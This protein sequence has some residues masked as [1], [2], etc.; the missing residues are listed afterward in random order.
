MESNGLF[1]ISSL[2]FSESS[3][4]NKLCNNLSSFLRSL[5]KDEFWP[6]VFGIDKLHQSGKTETFVPYQN[7]LNEL[8]CP[9]SNSI[10]DFV[11]T[12]NDDVLGKIQIIVKD[13]PG[14]SQLVK[15]ELAYY[16]PQ[17]LKK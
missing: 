14:C 11:K 2:Q 6:L 3:I 1:W 12:V 13:N 4:E 5:E 7:A 17:K 15:C 9:S 10:W 8:T 16:I